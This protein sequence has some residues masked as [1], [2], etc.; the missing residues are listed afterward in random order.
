MMLS[1]STP[2]AQPALPVPCSLPQPV[3]D[4]PLPQIAECLRE[5]LFQHPFAYDIDLATKLSAR[6]RIVDSP[7]E[8]CLPATSS[9]PIPSSLMLKITRF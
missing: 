3:P 8:P 6:S 2:L 4:C 9:N 7:Y 1:L 5:L